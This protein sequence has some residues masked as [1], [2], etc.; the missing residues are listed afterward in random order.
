MGELREALDWKGELRELLG[1][2]LETNGQIVEKDTSLRNEYG[3]VFRYGIAVDTDKMTHWG[4]YKR[5]EKYGTGDVPEWCG[6]AQITDVHEENVSEFTDT[7]ADNDNYEVLVGEIDCK[8]GYLKADRVEWR[9]SMRELFRS[10]L[11]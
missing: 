1:K 2:L 10:V 6:Q 4:R 3:N 8:C 5:S 7:E 11:A 9:V